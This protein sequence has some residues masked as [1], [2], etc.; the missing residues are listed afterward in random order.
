[1]NRGSLLKKVLYSP[2]FLAVIPAVIIMLFLP[3]VGLRNTLIVEEKGS[4]LNKDVYS[5]LNSDSITEIV[6][7]GKGYPYH[8]ILIFDNNLRIYDQWNLKD[9]LDPGLSDFFFG[10]C[11]NDRFS[12]I[13]IFSYKDDSVFLNVNEYFDPQGIKYD[14]AFI[15]TVRIV[16]RTITSSVF[17][18]G[19]YDVNGDGY[20]E[21]Y[22]SIATGFGLEPRLVYYFDILAKKLKTGEFTGVNCQMTKSADTDGDKKPEIFGLMSANGNYKVHTPYSDLSTWFMVFDEE[23]NLEFPP[24]EFPGL[25]NKLD[26]NSYSVNDFKGYVLNHITNTADTTVMEPRIMVFSVDG[27]K[28]RE[29]IYKDLG[30]NMNVFLNILPGKNGDRIFLFEKDMIELDENLNI[31][32]RIESPLNPLYYLYTVD[33]DMNGEKEFFLYSEMEEKLVVVNASL[34]VLAET[35]LK[36]IG[37][38]L[39]FSHMTSNTGD[40]KLFVASSDNSW[41]IEMKKNEFFYLGYLAYPGIYMIL[42][43]FIGGVNKINTHKVREKERL[44][45]RLLTLQLQGIKSQ[46]DPHFTFNAL[47]SIASLIYLEDRQSAYDYMNKFTQLLRAM[48]NDAERVY[49]SLAEEIEFVTT[50]L[51]L[52]KLRFGDKF[53]YIIDISDIVSQKEQVPKLVLQTYAENAIKHGLMPCVDGGIL[54]ITVIREDDYLKLSIEDNGVG[55][56][57]SLGKSTSTGKGLKLTGEFYDILNQMNRNDIRHTLTDLYNINGT[58]AGT[59]VDVWVPVSI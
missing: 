56:E 49:R 57:K 54:K 32:T 6:R 12:E 53:N 10:N 39:R 8:H 14:R 24:A 11:D 47:N 17:P 1:M 30:L 3:P 45:Q 21:L 50:Y 20:K 43:L 59:R 16:N 36:T 2:W 33:I 18:A 31:I 58:P 28:I 15:S 40:Q 55:R 29:L 48:L 52:E 38:N 37:Y 46:L 41:F 35:K 26:I 4:H 27:E 9:T 25:T 13:Y 51:E 23:L 44:K 7:T 42:L 5:D 34:Q 22:F 19:F